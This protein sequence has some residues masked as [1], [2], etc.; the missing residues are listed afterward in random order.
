MGKIETLYYRVDSRSK[1]GMTRYLVIAGVS[2]GQIVDLTWQIAEALDWLL[3]KHGRIV[4]KGCGYNP[5]DYILEGLRGLPDDHLL[6]GVKQYEL[7][8]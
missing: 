7:L 4:A 6:A 1:S 3:D 5:M 2:D 8:P